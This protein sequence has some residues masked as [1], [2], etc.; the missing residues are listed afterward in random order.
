MG[1]SIFNDDGK[2]A[3]DLLTKRRK[4]TCADNS[5]LSN[6]GTNQKVFKIILELLGNKY[7]GPK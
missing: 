4:Q 3:W 5:Y 2:W 7:N 1:N 6:N